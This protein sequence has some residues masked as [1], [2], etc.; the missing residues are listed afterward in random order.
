MKNTKTNKLIWSYDTSNWNDEEIKDEYKEIYEETPTETEL[1]EYK[2]TINNDDLSIM[3]S[4][5]LHYERNHSTK[6]Y[7]VKATL[8]LWYGVYDGG[9][10]IESLESAIKQTFEDYNEIYIERRR[11]KVKAIHHDGT[12]F[13]QFK[14]LTKR[15]EEYYERHKHGNQ[16]QL[17]ET[18]FKNSHYSHEVSMINEIYGW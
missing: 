4:E 6:L 12:N 18:L 5:I 2:D 15:G 13:Y 17:V 16:Q 10:V 1:E 8:G 9:K 3:F 14:E 11:L 7:V